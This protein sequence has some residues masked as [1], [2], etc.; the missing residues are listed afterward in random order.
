LLDSALP[1]LEI[2]HDFCD[3]HR[4]APTRLKSLGL[5]RI[6]TKKSSLPMRR[7]GRERKECPDIGIYIAIYSVISMALCE[8]I[9]GGIG[10]TGDGGLDI[11]GEVDWDRT[12][13]RTVGGLET[14]GGYCREKQ[15]H[16]D[17]GNP[18]RV[19]GVGLRCASAVAAGGVD[20]GVGE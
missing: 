7:E 17:R 6:E 16:F 18:V 10:L 20:C 19:C 12:D 8:Q 14:I 15:C 11:I 1:V 2:Q 9:A 5:I 4:P 3:G 13:R